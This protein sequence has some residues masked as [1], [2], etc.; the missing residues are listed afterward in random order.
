M[1]QRASKSYLGLLGGKSRSG[2]TR[3]Q[4]DCVGKWTVDPW[5]LFTGLYQGVPIYY[6]RDEKASDG[7]KVKPFP[8]MKNL[9]TDKSPQWT[10]S[11]DWDYLK[12]VLIEARE[13]GSDPHDNLMA[14]NKPRQM[15]FSHTFLGFAMWECLFEEATN[16]MV[17]KL[18]EKGSIRI[19]REKVLFPYSKFPDWFKQAHPMNET[20]SE[21]H[22]LKT[23]SYMTA[24]AQN[25]YKSE[26]L[27][28][29]GNVLIDEAWTCDEVQAGVEESLPMARR[30][31]LLGTPG[32]GGP[33]TDYGRS[34]VEG[35]EFE[36]DPEGPTIPGDGGLTA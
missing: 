20:Q 12:V 27:G 3:E 18:Q 7:V 32:L 17:C 26:S 36:A 31:I 11:S 13:L 33:A 2:L 21:Y 25:F 9:G 1:S 34:M 30:V 14:V 5:N 28:A 24:V 22:F 35:E 19:M 4:E 29:S 16:W 6:T 10:V 15:F 23:D 8:A